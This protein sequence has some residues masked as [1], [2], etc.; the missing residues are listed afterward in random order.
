[1]EYLSRTLKVVGEKTQ[2][3][4]QPRCKGVKLNHLCFADDIILCSSGDFVSVY[5]MLQ[6]FQHFS[7]ASGL[8][9]NVHKTK[10]FTVG[11]NNEARQRLLNATGS[12]IGSLPFKYLGVPINHKRLVVNEG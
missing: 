4:Y 7:E 9:V 10:M 1:M 6:G 11:L 3:K 2:F 8:E 12:K 5:T